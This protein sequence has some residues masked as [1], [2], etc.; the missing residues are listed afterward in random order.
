MVQVKEITSLEVSQD[1][2]IPNLHK[3]VYLSLISKAYNIN[4]KSDDYRYITASVF[5]ILGY[6]LYKQYSK[7]RDF[8]RYLYTHTI[9]KKGRTLSGDLNITKTLEDKAFLNGRVIKDLSFDTRVTEIRLDIINAIMYYTEELLY[10]IKNTKKN[11]KNSI[12][13]NLHEIAIDLCNTVQMVYE[14]DLVDLKQKYEN[15]ELFTIV[16][17]LDFIDKS[18]V[19][20]KKRSASQNK[21][22]D[23]CLD[24]S[25]RH[26]I[27]RIIRN[28]IKEQTKSN[29]IRVYRDRFKGSESNP[30][31]ETDI[32]VSYKDL[33]Y[34]ILEIKTGKLTDKNRVDFSHQVGDYINNTKNKL[35]NKYRGEKLADLISAMYGV[36]IILEGNTCDDRTTY[37]LSDVTSFN[38]IKNRNKNKDRCFMSINLRDWDDNTGEELID[39]QLNKLVELCNNYVTTE[40]NR[41]QP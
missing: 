26:L 12:V 9:T 35:V 4:I 15:T 23:H 38:D 39:Q 34:L 2:L 24:I 7:D 20:N 21:L 17:I 16:N 1:M 13:Q 6:I 19:P 8:G 29:K 27:E 37:K 32:T 3:R 31:S 33:V 25:I 22:E 36:V 41:I 40:Y 14:P 10:C 30:S 11:I 18:I 28:K 5:E